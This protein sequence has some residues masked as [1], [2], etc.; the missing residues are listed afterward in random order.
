M[1]IPLDKIEVRKRQRSVM[2]RTE[3]NELKETIVSIG[4][5]HPP[6][7][8]PDNNTGTWVLSVG[9]RRLT[10]IRELHAEK[11]TFRHDGQE[12]PLGQIP[13]TRLDDQIDEI[14]RFEAEL[15]ENVRRSD[16]SWQDRVRAYADLHTMRQLQSGKQQTPQSKDFTGTAQ[17]LV[18]RGITKNINTARAAVQEAVLI[19]K[20]LDNDKIMKAR[21]PA[22]AAGLIYK[23]EE[24]HITAALV[25]RN[26]TQLPSSSS[27]RLRHGDALTLLEGLDSDMADLIL[28]DPPYGL[29]A[30]SGGF[31]ARTVHHHNYED[32]PENAKKIAR[33]V[34]T[35][36]FRI[37][38]TR[39]N[40]F[41]FC[42]IE[43]FDWLKST[44]ANMGWSPFRRP[45]IWQKSESEGMAPWGGSGPRITTE[46]I[47]FATK[48]QR[49]LNASPI[50]VFNVKR[51]PRSERIH[52]AEKPVELLK[53]L[54]QCSTLPND[55][56]LDPCCGSGSTL[57][58]AKELKRQALGIELDLDYYNTAMANVFGSDLD[59]TSER[60]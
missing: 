50:D 6:V 32:T 44:A 4:L 8:W 13:A 34:L 46:F 37:C 33:T 48:G 41:M 60:T 1:L 16:L 12:V 23:M 35:E 43:L 51:V 10:A 21:N 49:G 56:V 26:L 18:N 55:L 25:K 38:K 27:I 7:F 17:E 54:I 58:A 20:H 57:V 53:T 19:A 47:F 31:R 15:D 28:I 45:L 3:L 40:I 39:A 30:A 22:E 2:D 14:G 11:R 36:G 24:E 29:G 59:A 9:E 5:L 52:A 42:D